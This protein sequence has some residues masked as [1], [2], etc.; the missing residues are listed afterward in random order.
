[1]ISEEQDMPLSFAYSVVAYHYGKKLQSKIKHQILLLG[2]GGKSLRFFLR[3]K[4]KGIHTH[5]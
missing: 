5:S 1:M 2:L 3:A 4:I